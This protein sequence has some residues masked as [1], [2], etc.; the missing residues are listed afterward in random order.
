MVYGFNLIGL[1]YGT[2]AGICQHDDKPSHSIKAG[3][4]LAGVSIDISRK[5][6][7]VVRWGEKNFQQKK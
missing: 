6:N 2:I 1:G 3:N 7:H 4:L 5:L